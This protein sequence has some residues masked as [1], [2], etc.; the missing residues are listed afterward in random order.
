MLLCTAL[1]LLLKRL[2][3]STCACSVCSKNLVLC[4]CFA[5]VPPL[6]MSQQQHQL[7]TN[8]ALHPPSAQAGLTNQTGQGGTFAGSEV[9]R[10]P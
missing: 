2:T 7:G 1:L 3:C 4:H 6:G 5:G 8:Y 10:L 9:G